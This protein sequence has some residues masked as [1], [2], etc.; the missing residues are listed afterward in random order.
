MSKPDWKDAPEWA[1]WVAC[2][3]TGQWWWFSVKPIALNWI[4]DIEDLNG[5]VDC[6]DVGYPVQRNKNWRE[7]LERRP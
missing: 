5:L 3:C 2:D 6:P 4:W 7:T 1:Q